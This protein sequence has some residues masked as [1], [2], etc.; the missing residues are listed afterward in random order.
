MIPHHAGGHVSDA[1]ARIGVVADGGQPACRQVPAKACIVVV[2]IEID[3]CVLAVYNRI[4][5]ARWR[6]RVSS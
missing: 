1:T 6:C 2:K 4:T 5:F 3:L